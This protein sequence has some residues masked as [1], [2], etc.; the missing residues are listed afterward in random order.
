VL[1][2]IFHEVW[3]TGR[4]VTVVM[5]PWFRQDFFHKAV[6]PPKRTNATLKTSEINPIRA[7]IF[8]KIPLPLFKKPVNPSFSVR[9]E[10][11]PNYSPV[12]QNT[13]VL[14]LA[15]WLPMPLKPSCFLHHTLAIRYPQ[16]LPEHQC[17]DNLEGAFPIF[18]FYL[19][20]AIWAEFCLPIGA[21]S[22]HFKLQYSPL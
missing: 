22:G 18:H 9:V 17:E 5:T 2:L 19:L 10:N 21:I 15:C 12:C 4:I 6:S 14:H 16:T 11:T 3:N 8:S 20:Q 7:P 1:C 13:A